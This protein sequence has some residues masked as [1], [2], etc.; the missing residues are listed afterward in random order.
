M[1]I[2]VGREH[3]PPNQIQLHLAVSIIIGF[4]F[5]LFKTTLEAY[6]GSQARGQ[7]GAA[8]ARLCHSHS[9][10]RSKP[11]LQATPQIMKTLDT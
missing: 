10:A 2:S 6:G 3:K 8:A 4:F 7:T 1:E 5:F 11:H 9:N